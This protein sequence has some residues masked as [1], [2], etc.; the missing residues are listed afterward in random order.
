VGTGLYTARSQ[1]LEGKSEANMYGYQSA[2]NMQEITATRR[3]AEEY[4]KAIS[5]YAK[6]Q[7]E[8]I[9]GT[10]ALNINVI[11]TAAA[12]EAKLL[13]RDVAQLRGRQM[14]A[15]GAMGIGGGVTAENIMTS[16]FDKAQLDKMAIR[17]NANIKSW[18]ISEMAK[19]DI[20]TLGGETKYKLWSSKEET[21][22]KIS[23]LRGE[24]G[25]FGLAAKGAKRAGRTR[26]AATLLSTAASVAKQGKTLVKEED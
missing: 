12:E 15:I 18:Q 5:G 10:A 20:W 14:A 26:A 16:T 25:Q 13:S 21:R 17:Y 3:Y 6:G 7:K 1:Y 23:A 8:A 11:Q 19:R 24:I 2:L 4:Q 22:M 9:K